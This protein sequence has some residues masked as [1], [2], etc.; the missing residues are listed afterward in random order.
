MQVLGEHHLQ[1]KVPFNGAKA[2]FSQ[3]DCCQSQIRDRIHPKQAASRAR[4]SKQ[5]DGCW[6]EASSNTYHFNPDR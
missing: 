6:V 3:A 5:P 1:L 2:P 4:E